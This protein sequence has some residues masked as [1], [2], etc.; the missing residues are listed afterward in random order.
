M[1]ARQHDERRRKIV[2]LAFGCG[3]LALRYLLWWQAAIVAAAALAF[4]LFVLPRVAGQLYRHGERPQSARSGIVLYPA[5]VLL[6][7]FVFHERLDIAAAGSLEDP[8][9]AAV[10]LVR[11]GH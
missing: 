11:T 8:E 1:A 7:I 10:G 4:N 6:L 3:A 2:H 9:L 5:S